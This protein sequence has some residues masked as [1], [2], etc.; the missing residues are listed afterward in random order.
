MFHEVVDELIWD[1][2]NG[3][4]NIEEKPLVFRRTR[5][6]PGSGTLSYKFLQLDSE[7]FYAGGMIPGRYTCDG[8]NINPPINIGSLPEKARSLAIVVDDPDGIDGSICHWVAWN[9]PITDHIEEAEHRGLPGRNDF[10][11]YKYI[12]PCPPVGTHRYYFKVYALDCVL[13]IPASAG[14]LQLE[15]AMRDH[16]VGFGF[17]VGKYASVRPTF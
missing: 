7:A 12:G 1:E 10:G 13:D 15:K 16:V 3:I 2:Q 14:K 8:K 17:L 4:P 5:H 9:I 11:F 6:E